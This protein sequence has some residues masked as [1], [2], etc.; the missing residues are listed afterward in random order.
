[1]ASATSFLA[2]CNFLPTVTATKK[3]LASLSPSSKPPS[4]PQG[5]LI[6]FTRFF[7]PSATH[8]KAII[9]HPP[10]H[11]SSATAKP[12]CCKSIGVSKEDKSTP[13]ESNS[14]APLNLETLDENDQV[15]LET[16]DEK[17]Q[18]DLRR[19]EEKFVVLNTGIY[20][21]GS[22]GYRYDENLG[23][24]SYPV[25]P[26]MPFSKLPDDWRC[27]TC[28][29]AR[30]FFKSKSVEI[31]GFAQNQQFGFG[32]NALTSGQKAILIYGSLFFFFVLFLSGY[33]IQ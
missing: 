29:A 13:D 21:C 20:E 7:I 10:A 3:T 6:L 24:P 25:P 22:C 1:M 14:K 28:G 19:F 4:V 30:S 27:P 33:F 23:D 11:N 32:G 17:P 2:P 12:F 8:P 9:S 5:T 26:G 16:L 18:V 15:N 31:A